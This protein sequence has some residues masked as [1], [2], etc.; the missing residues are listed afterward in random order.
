MTIFCLTRSIL[1]NLSLDLDPPKQ[2]VRLLCN[3]YEKFTMHLTSQPSDQAAIT[4]SR[5]AACPPLFVCVKPQNAPFYLN[6]TVLFGGALIFF[7]FHPL[8]LGRPIKQS[9]HGLIYNTCPM[10]SLLPTFSRIWFTNIATRL[11]SPC[12][13]RYA[14]FS[15]HTPASSLYFPLHLIVVILL[16]FLDCFCHHTTMPCTPCFISFNCCIFL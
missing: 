5:C 6:E 3:W 15:R 13:A 14:C 11:F 16:L 1:P 7:K 4:S 9:S 10:V 12:A 8:N 2:R